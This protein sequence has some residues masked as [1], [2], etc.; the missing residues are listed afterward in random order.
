MAQRL[1]LHY[2]PGN[3]ILHRWDAR[4]KLIG[5]L[6]VTA[7]LLRTTWTWLVLNSVFL[8]CL[9]LL[10]R[11]PVRSFLRDLK[12]WFLFLV[13]L[14]CLSGFL[15]S[16]FRRLVFFRVFLSAAKDFVWEP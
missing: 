5:L 13:V 3:S 9:L 4:C 1:A 12:H 14:F 2:F 15:L 8:L 11:L 6:M 16:P 7:T 10:S